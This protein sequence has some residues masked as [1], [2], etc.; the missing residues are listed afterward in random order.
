M[1]EYSSD[2]PHQ[3]PHRL[4][5]TQG[6]SVSATSVWNVFY[7]DSPV[8]LFFMAMDMVLMGNNGGLEIEI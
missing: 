2:P 7:R 6:W 4:M 1:T 5:A 3:Q 8:F